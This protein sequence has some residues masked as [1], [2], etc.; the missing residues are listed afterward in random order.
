MEGAR[1]PGAVS[2]LPSF[3]QVAGSRLQ[4]PGLGVGGQDH[5]EEGPQVKLG[6]GPG[7]CAPQAWWGVFLALEEGTPAS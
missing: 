3:Q 4:Q 2:R 6:A 5:A 1:L 7:G